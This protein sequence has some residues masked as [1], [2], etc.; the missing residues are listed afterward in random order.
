MAPA[1]STA[2]LDGNL[3]QNPALRAK[4]FY[5]MNQ[6]GLRWFRN[7]SS[8]GIDFSWRF[9]ETAPGVYNW[10]T[11]DTLVRADQQK[12]VALLASIGNSVPQWA[13]GSPDWRA[14][15][16]DLYT[17]PMP[18]TAWYQYVQHV[19]ERYDG[20]G[21][22]DMP[23]LTRPIKFWKLWNEPDL[24]D[25][26]SGAARQFNGTVQ[27]YVRLSRLGY[28]AVKA[29]DPGAQVVGPSSAQQ[30]G[31]IVHAPGLLWTLP[32]WVQ[33][34]GLAF[35]DIFAFHAY[36]DRTGWDPSGA[37]DQMLNKLDTSRGGKPVWVTEIGWN[38]GTTSGY[39]DKDNN[40]VRSVIIF[41]QRPDIQHYFWYDRQESETYSGSNHKAFLQTLNGDAA[42]GS[43][44]DPL[45]HPI[46]RV[47]Q[48]LARMLAGLGARPTALDVSGAARAYHLSGNGRE[49]WVA[50][51]RAASGSA[52][53]NLDT[54]GKTVR[55][56]DLY[57]RNQGTLAGGALTVGPA[58]V[59][60][61]TQL[62][63]ASNLGTITGRVRHAS[64]AGQ[65]ADG[66]SGVTVSL[67]GPVN[68][69]ATTDGDGNYVFVGLPDGEYGVTVA[70]G[71]PASQ[72]VTVA[73]QAPWGRT[74]FAVTP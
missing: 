29:A 50:W 26:G 39:Q 3:S 16:T 30:A 65:W 13:S 57:G 52:T 64:Q 45:F 58:P 72:N 17:N 60:L 23:G 9:V 33:A 46:F 14:K 41:W 6:A 61:T 67:S 37:V 15:P 59:H 69:T 10:I 54:G 22:A 63:W 44:P 28:S 40:F 21:V 8:D 74:S 51:L 70:G 36:F 66:A 2:P 25:A 7:Y 32:D 4:S 71:S 73:G 55:V 48:V 20:D 42:K 18:S 19:V 68:A 34:G 27:D 1:L 53:I 49:V 31:N 12:D 47:A 38:G 43:E 56:V 35:V 11:W 62:D 5:W 24:R